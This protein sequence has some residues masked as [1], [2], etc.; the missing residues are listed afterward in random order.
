MRE[1]ERDYA[2]RIRAVGPEVPTWDVRVMAWLDVWGPPASVVVM[3][4]G[5]GYVVAQIV[6]AFVRGVIPSMGV[7]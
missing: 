2:G 7:Q 5:A 1:W 3:A 6:I 4:V